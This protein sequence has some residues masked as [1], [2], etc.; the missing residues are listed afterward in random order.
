ML[1]QTVQVLHEAGKEVILDYEVHQL[2]QN[3]VSS[4]YSEF[5][6]M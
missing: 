6:Q 2:V 3:K 4:R 5:Y 1:H